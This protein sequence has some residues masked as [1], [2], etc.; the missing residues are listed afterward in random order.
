M[1]FF[2]EKIYLCFKKRL[3]QKREIIRSL[4]PD[5]YPPSYSVC[6]NCFCVIWIYC[7]NNLILILFRAITMFVTVLP[8][9][10]PS[11]TCHPKLDNNTALPVLGR[12]TRLTG[13]RK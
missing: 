8:K 9:S 10:D 3:S 12:S 6:S 11:Y 2:A 13:F 1:E 7:G 5:P 4:P